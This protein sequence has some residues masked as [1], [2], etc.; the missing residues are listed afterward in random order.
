MPRRDGRQQPEWG[1]PRAIV[2]GL[3]DAW[4]SRGRQSCGC[5]D[6]ERQTALNT[7]LAA[8]PITD[9]HVGYREALEAVRELGCF[10]MSKY[11]GA[12]VPW[13]EAKLRES[14]VDVSRFPTR[15]T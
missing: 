4:N 8:L 5:W 7:A 14:K 2:L 10:S 11:A 3:V 12:W 15:L 1:V 6:A 13:M 9:D